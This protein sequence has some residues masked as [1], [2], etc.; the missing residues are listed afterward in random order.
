L[1]IAGFCSLTGFVVEN[2]VLVVLINT[3]RD[4]FF[5]TYKDLQGDVQQINNFQVAEDWKVTKY[6]QASRQ[7]GHDQF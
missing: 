5:S 6:F 7:G 3:K 4:T 2:R 1:K